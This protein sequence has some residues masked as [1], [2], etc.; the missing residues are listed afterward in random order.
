MEVKSKIGQTVLEYIM[1][2]LA[3][4]VLV[5]GVYVFKF[6]NNFSFGGVTGIS[7][8]RCGS[9]VFTGVVYICHQYGSSCYRIYL[10]WEELRN[11]DS[12]CERAYIG[13]LKSV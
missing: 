7:V 11:K 12:V 8:I 9:A 6:P 13:W 4:L 1:L 2:T 5:V 3:T 10:S